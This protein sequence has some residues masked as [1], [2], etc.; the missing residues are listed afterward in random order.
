[1]A[2]AFCVGAVACAEPTA[3]REV[4]QES[5]LLLRVCLALKSASP[6]PSTATRLKTRQFGIQRG[7]VYK[8]DRVVIRS[9]P[10]VVTFGGLGPQY[11]ER[12]NRCPKMFGTP[13][14]TG[15]YELVFFRNWSTRICSIVAAVRRRVF[16]DNPPLRSAVPLTSLDFLYHRL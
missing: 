12:W 4:A 9:V 13:I 7:C 10:L 15:L 14:L 11:F 5:R 1:V 6:F 8:G 3:M 2:I 16:F